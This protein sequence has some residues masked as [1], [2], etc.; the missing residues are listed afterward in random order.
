MRWFRADMHIHTVLSPCGGLDMSPVNIIQQAVRQKLN[1]IAR[2][3]TT[4]SIANRR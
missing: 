4:A 1:I 3:E 2:T